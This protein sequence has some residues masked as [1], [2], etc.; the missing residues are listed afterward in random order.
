M[1]VF[2]SKPGAPNASTRRA[3]Q[4]FLDA[5]KK[6]LYPGPLRLPDLLDAL[7]AAGPDDDGALEDVALEVY[8]TDHYR[9]FEKVRSQGKAFLSGAIGAMMPFVAT[10]G[11]A[12]E[13][14]R[15]VVRRS[16]EELD[17]DLYLRSEMQFIVR[18]KKVAA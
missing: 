5:Y 16:M 11:L 6:T 1:Q 3:V 17:G 7:G 9:D 13:E 14:V 4:F 18:R 8:P 12:E 2:T 10:E 15:E